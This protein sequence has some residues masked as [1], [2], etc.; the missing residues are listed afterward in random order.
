MKKSV[1][2]VKSPSLP[3]APIQYIAMIRVDAETKKKLEN[4]RF[5]S[6][7]NPVSWELHLI[8]SVENGKFELRKI[9]E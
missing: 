4:F 7:L 9:L 8:V 2:S 6:S 3:P 5:Q 1:D